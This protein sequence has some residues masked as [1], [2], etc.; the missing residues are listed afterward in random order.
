MYATLFNNQKYTFWM[1]DKIFFLLSKKKNI[2]AMSI[3]VRIALIISPY[4]LKINVVITFSVQAEQEKKDT[5]LSYMYNKNEL[6]AK[7]SVELNAIAKELGI[8]LPSR[9]DAQ[10][11]IYKILDTQ[12]KDM[13]KEDPSNDTD[14]QSRQRRARLKPTPI[15][16]SN[17]KNANGT[18]NKVAEPTKQQSNTKQ[19]PNVKQ[20]TNTKQQ[21]NKKQQNNNKQQSNNQRKAQPQNNDAHPTNKKVEQPISDALNLNISGLEVPKIPEVMDLINRRIDTAAIESVKEKINSKSETAVVPAGRKTIEDKLPNNLYDLKIADS[22]GDDDEDM[23]TVTIT[24]PDVIMSEPIEI[25]VKRRRGRPKKQDNETETESKII[26]PA[27]SV[28]ESATQST[29]KQQSLHNERNYQKNNNLSNRPSNP[30]MDTSKDSQDN[31][32]EEDY[33]PS[34]QPNNKNK[35]ITTDTKPQD[36][37]TLNSR[38]YREQRY[39]EMVSMLEGVVECEGVL[40]VVTDGY[41]FLRS[42]DY[43]YLPSPDDVYVATNHIRTYGLKTGD[44]VCGTIRPP[45]ES[46]KYFPLIKITEINGLTPDEIRDRIPFESLTPLFPQEKFKLT[47]HPGETLSTRIIDMFTP[48]GKGQRSLRK[49]CRF[50]LPIL[51]REIPYKRLEAYCL[52]IEASLSP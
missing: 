52:G 5:F 50:Q 21:A 41:G 46:D 17:V 32:F 36:D 4:T 1:N 38:K 35:S 14:A 45:K 20:Q 2:F 24:S 6:Q 31:D 44:T 8:F 11:L 10:T 37:P 34:Q 42:S 9:Y 12:A 13:S 28:P 39:N 51:L 7:S 30:N 47:G 29:P 23:E 26:E 25:P 48:I 43:N 33:Y 49:P 27:N 16:E 19:Q 40:E 3:Q 22:I 15:A 18:K